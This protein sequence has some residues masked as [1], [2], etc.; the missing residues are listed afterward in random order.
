MCRSCQNQLVTLTS[1]GVSSPNSPLKAYVR[2]VELFVWTTQNGRL[3]RG[4][5]LFVCKLIHLNSETPLLFHKFPNLKKIQEWLLN[6]KLNRKSLI[7]AHFLTKRV[8]IGDWILMF[9]SYLTLNIPSLGRQR[10]LPSWGPRRTPCFF[11]FCHFSTVWCGRL[12][13][14]CFLGFLKL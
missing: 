1:T 9:L 11:F 4:Y 7:K 8:A 2:R 12:L 3:T 10:C 14:L 5:R 13:K 6:K